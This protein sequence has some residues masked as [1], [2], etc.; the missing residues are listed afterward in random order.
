V[1]A[2]ASRLD[3]AT[4]KRVNTNQESAAIQMSEE[5]EELEDEDGEGDE[6]EGRG[7]EETE[8]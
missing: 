8:E 7:D 4:R 5:D 3:G 2:E 6:D 1:L